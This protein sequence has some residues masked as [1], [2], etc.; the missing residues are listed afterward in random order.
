MEKTLHIIRVYAAKHKAQGTNVNYL[1]GKRKGPGKG[2]AQP[3]NN[4]KKEGCERAKAQ[5]Q[6]NKDKCRK[7]RKETH[8][9]GQKC[10][11][12]DQE[13]WFCKK[14]GHYE[15]VCR[16]KKS[17]VHQVIAEP[18]MTTMTVYTNEDSTVT[19]AHT[20]HIS[21]VSTVS[22]IKPLVIDDDDGA[23]GD[24]FISVPTEMSTGKTR[25]STW[26]LTWVLAE[27]SWVSKQSKNIIWWKCENGS[28]QN[29][30]QSIWEL[31]P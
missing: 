23:L 18:S 12:A 31:W 9:Q 19:Y 3:S 10:P 8:Q 2:K 6:D 16:E 13:C 1:K 29:S 15:V 26:R 24:I 25:R 5:N 17:T 21:M 4:N 22:L 28:T 20:H 7:C 30:W 14:R 11:A 27:T